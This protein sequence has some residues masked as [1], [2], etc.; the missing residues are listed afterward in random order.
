MQ[1]LFFIIFLSG[2]CTNCFGQLY[3]GIK[4]DYALT[5]SRSEEIVYDDELDFLTYKLRFIEQDVSPTVSAFARYEQ[6]LIYLQAT[7]GYRQIK[8]R[9]SSESFLDI[10]GTAPQMTIKNTGYV[11]MPFSAGLLFDRFHFGAGPVFGLI[12]KENPIF[13]EIENFEERRK[14]LDTGFHFCFGLSAGRL[15]WE[16]SYEYHFNSV[17]DYFYYR[18]DNKSFDTQAQFINLGMAFLF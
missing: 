11:R 1:K 17:A 7:I 14:R 4:L 15:Q 16:I 6:D 3:G 18:K 13:T 5:I 8:T 10:T 9:F 12:V 2:F